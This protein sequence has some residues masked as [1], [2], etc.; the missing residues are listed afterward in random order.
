MHRV[1]LRRGSAAWYCVYTAI[2]ARVVA[3]SDVLCWR[4]GLLS[5]CQM[6]RHQQVPP[7]KRHAA[8]R[9]FC[10]LHGAQQKLWPVAGLCHRTAQPASDTVCCCALG[11]KLRVLLNTRHPVLCCCTPTDSLC[12]AGLPRKCFQVHAAH[13][14][15]KGCSASGS[16]RCVLTAC[17]PAA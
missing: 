14:G 12:S 9:T 8:P 11:I 1:L 5:F 2:H 17:L 15:G 6:C 4:A 7:Q 10:R 16:C 13:Q 3:L